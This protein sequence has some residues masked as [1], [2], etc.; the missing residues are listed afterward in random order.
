MLARL[1]RLS[2]YFSSQL[3]QSQGSAVVEPLLS[4]STPVH[5]RPYDKNRY[6]IPMEKIKINSGI[7]PLMQD[8]PSSRSN[9]SLAQRS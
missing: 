2:R 1:T 7:F 4:S 5:L 8:T 6:E 9:H 3:Q